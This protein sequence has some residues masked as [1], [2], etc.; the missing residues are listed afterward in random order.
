MY[1]YCRISHAK[2]LCDIIGWQLGIQTLAITCNIL[3][4]T[5]SVNKTSS[6]ALDVLHVAIVCIMLNIIMKS[7]CFDN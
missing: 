2:L 5:K 4:I 6:S 7:V 3:Q 1:G